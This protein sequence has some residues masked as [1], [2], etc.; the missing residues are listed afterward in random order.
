MKNGIFAATKASLAFIATP[1]GMVLAGLA[2]AIGAVTQYFRDSEEGQNAW[3]KIA[4]VT[5]VV[6]GNLTDLLSDLGGMLFKTFSEPKR[7]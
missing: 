1:L 6:V 5:G 3:N 2:L 4:A 7:H